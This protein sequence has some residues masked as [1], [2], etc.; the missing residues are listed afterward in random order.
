MKRF[1][2]NC[3]TSGLGFRQR[4]PDLETRVTGF[5][6]DLN[7]SPMLLHNSLNGVE[8]EAGA[9]ANSLGGKKR[10]KDVGLYLA[11]NSRAVIADLNYYATV[12]AVGSDA[13]LAFAVHGVNRVIN[14][15]SPDLVELAAKRIHEKRNALVVA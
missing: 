7:I 12:I 1:L 10:L 9:F 5:G 3:P 14:N 11:G 15:V 13:K 8:A 6:T 2:T 4:E